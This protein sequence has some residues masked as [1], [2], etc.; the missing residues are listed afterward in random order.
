M[1]KKSKNLKDNNYKEIYYVNKSALPVT[2]TKPY[3]YTK[4]TEF[5]RP[6]LEYTK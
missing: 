1:E 4:P 5:L 6:I 3:T 2:I